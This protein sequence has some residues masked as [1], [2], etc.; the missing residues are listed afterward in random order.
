M[1]DIKLGFTIRNIRTSKRTTLREVADITKLTTSFI[2]Q[3]ERGI[4]SPSI[5]SLRKIARALN[6][7]IGEVFEEDLKNFT[8]IRK[9]KALK[10]VDKETK[11]SYEILVSDLLGVEMKPLI[12]RL[13]KGGKIK[14]EVLLEQGD[15]FV[16]LMEG[17]VE[18]FCEEERFVL[19]KGDSFYCKGRKRPQKIANISSEE[20]VLLWIKSR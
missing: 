13:Q 14:K 15:T 18:L 10:V 6:V 9:D 7:S 19:N 11:S 1:L 3:V 4:V 2:S 12:F 20:A 16:M 8:F 5:D 17:E